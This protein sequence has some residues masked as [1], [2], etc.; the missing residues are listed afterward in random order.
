[1][2]E[3]NKKNFKEA[4][5]RLNLPSQEPIKEIILLLLN[6]INKLKFIINNKT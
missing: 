6:E 3:N 4:L 5:D 1:M 2:S